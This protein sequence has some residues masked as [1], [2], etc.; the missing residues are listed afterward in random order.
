MLL[1]KL[2]RHLPRVFARKWV[3]IRS[4]GTR[5]AA[6]SVYLRRDLFELCREHGRLGDVVACAEL[7][8]MKIGEVTYQLHP[9]M[10]KYGSVQISATTLRF[11]WENI[12]H[13]E[14]D[15]TPADRCIGG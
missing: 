8:R 9:R 10:D 11:L 15:S 7:G 6:F 1:G 2:K 4:R 12:G 14:V 13:A 3:R 5:F